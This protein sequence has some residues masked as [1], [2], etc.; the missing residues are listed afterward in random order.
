MFLTRLSTIASKE[1]NRVP[2]ENQA[3]KFHLLKASPGLQYSTCIQSNN[4]SPAHARCSKTT[5]GLMQSQ[6]RV[7]VHL[8][9]R[10]PSGNTTKVKDPPSINSYSMLHPIPG[11]TPTHLL[12]PNW[13]PRNGTRAL[14]PCEWGWGEGWEARTER[15]RWSQCALV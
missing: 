14:K 4:P 12:Q 15:G 11:G 1:R 7:F 5:S 13:D 2:N 10:G 9:V 6:T 8:G 3:E